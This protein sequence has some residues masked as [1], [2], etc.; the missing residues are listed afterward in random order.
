MV[1]QGLIPVHIVSSKGLE[2]DKSNI[3]VIESLPYP[4]CVCEV[5]SSNVQKILSESFSL[6]L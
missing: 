3:N 2:I 1:D 4:A 5:Y 6:N